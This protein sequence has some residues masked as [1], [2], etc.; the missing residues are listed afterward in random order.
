[1]IL[2]LQ[3]LIDG[4]LIGGVYATMAVGLS[5]AFG[6]MRIINW[7]QGELLMVSMYISYFVFTWLGM[8]P[9]LIVF[10]TAFVLF[11]VGYI[12]QKGVIGNLLDRSNEREPISVLLFTAGLGMVLSNA[13][14][15]FIG[16]NPLSEQTR[17]TG[18]MLEV[19][20]ILVSVPKLISF[21]F[22]LCLTLLLYTLLQKSEVG[23]AIRATAQNRS[24]ATLMGIDQKKIYRLSF[25]LSLAMVGASGA[26]LIP[27]YP[28]STT[29]GNIF[30]FKTF[31][32]VVLGGM[33][34][35]PGALL[36]GL[37]VGIIEKVIGQAW[38]DTYA[39]ILVF[40]IFVAVLLFKPNGLMGEKDL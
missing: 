1:M 18:Q 20:T 19:G 5:L 9:Y 22:A 3:A 16:S 21:D 7:C 31:V 37:L 24:V 13:A 34:S 17:Y 4:L 30:S 39:Q 33:G 26:L 36:G 2:Y 6:V 32:I 38:S 15:V 29:V 35:V 10:L 11:C 8:D 28:V 27:Y 25:G 12:L 40:V 14:L 23:R